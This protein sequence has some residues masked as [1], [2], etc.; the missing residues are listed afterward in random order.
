MHPAEQAERDGLLTLGATPQS[1]IPWPPE[2]VVLFQTKLFIV[3]ESEMKLPETP[4]LAAVTVTVLVP[5]ELA[6]TPTAGNDVLQEV[7]A[8]A[9]LDASVEPVE[10]LTKVPVVVLVHPFV[11]VPPLRFAPDHKN[12]APLCPI[13]MLFPEGPAVVVWNAARIGMNSPVWGCGMTPRSV[14]V[15]PI[16]ESRPCPS[17]SPRQGW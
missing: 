14:K 9:K 13:A 17:P 6:V 3:S 8:A 16:Y 5:P 15:P 4:V 2:S 12:P 1:P 11:P 7:I 10:L